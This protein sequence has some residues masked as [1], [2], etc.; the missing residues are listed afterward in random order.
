[1]LRK[2]G[3]G[4]ISYHDDKTV[5]Y[6]SKAEVEEFSARLEA[7]ERSKTEELQEAEARLRS[8]LSQASGVWTDQDVSGQSFPA[9]ISV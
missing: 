1:V 8:E 6:K 3:L 5:V 2:A 4:T 7:K 9:D